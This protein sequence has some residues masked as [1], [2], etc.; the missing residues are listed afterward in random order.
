[1]G[2]PSARRWATV[3]VLLL[4][5]TLAGCATTHPRDPLEPVNRAI[6]HFN[7]GIDTVVL[8]PIASGYREIFPQ[9]VRTGVSNF[10]SNI[11]DI[12]VIINNLLQLKIPEALSDIGRFALN[13]TVGILGLFDV[14]THFGLEKHNEDFGQTLGYWGIGSGPYLVLPILGPSSFRDGIGRWLDSRVDLVWREDHIRTRNQFV[15]TRAV[16][17]RARLIESERVMEAAAIDRYAFLRDAYL[18]RRRNLVYD[19]N[20]PPEPD[21]EEFLP[22]RPQSEAEPAIYSVL[23][24]QYGAVVAGDPQAVSGL[25]FQPRAS[26]AVPPEQRVPAARAN[27]SSATQARPPGGGGNGGDTGAS[28]PSAERGRVVHVWL[29]SSDP[30]H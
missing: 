29:P 18:Q 26:P 7:D 17:D 2:A 1:M 23:V 4:A 22:P 10:F 21:D 16:S 13:T 27:P 8:K 5:G 12:N 25:V 28:G 9:F 15:A 24:D 11:D 3:A 20:P 6:Y 30:R 14:A 19:G